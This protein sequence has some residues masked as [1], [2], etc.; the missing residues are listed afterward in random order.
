MSAVWQAST[1]G[2]GHHRASVIYLEISRKQSFASAMMSR[3]WLILA[4]AL[5]FT[6]ASYV[7]FSWAIQ[8]VWLSAF[9][10]ANIANLTRWFWLRMALG[11]FSSIGA[12]WAYWRFAKS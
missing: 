9:E 2:S 6:A 8:A 4:V 1:P 3:R 12:I 7:G 10:G 5:V 11:I